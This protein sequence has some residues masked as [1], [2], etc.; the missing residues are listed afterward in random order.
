M[1][2]PSRTLTATAVSRAAEVLHAARASSGTRLAMG[3]G[4]WS[5]PQGYA[6][7]VFCRTSEGNLSQFYAFILI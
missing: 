5:E 6:F 4:V 7:R 3:L 1:L 2:C